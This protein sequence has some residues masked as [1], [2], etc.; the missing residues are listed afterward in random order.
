MNIDKLLIEPDKYYNAIKSVPNSL[1]IYF[2]PTYPGGAGGKAGG[3]GGGQIYASPIEGRGDGQKAN[4]PPWPV[5]VTGPKLVPIDS[6]PTYTATVDWSANG[7]NSMGSQTI[8]Q[9]GETIHYRWESFNITQYAEEALAKKTAE[10]KKGAAAPS[11]LSYE[12]RLENLKNAKVGAGEDVTGMGGANREFHREFEHWAQD[13]RRA[14]KGAKN[15]GGDTVGER[16]SNATANRLALELAPV[17]L[18]TTAIGATLAWMAE[19]FAGPRRQQE[20]PLQKKGI[21]LIRTITTPAI[22]EDREGKQI[23]RPPSVDA[24]ITE[25]T[26]METSVKEALDEPS[27]QLAELKAQIDLA[28]KEGNT[29]KAE[30]LRELLAQ[31]QV[32]HEGTPLAVL[33]KSKQDK[34]RE[35]DQLRKEK[36][37]SAADSRQ[38]EL[39]LID[40]Q[41]KLY[42]RHD[43]ERTKDGTDLAPM[44][45]LNATLISEVTGEQYPLLIAAGPMAKKGDQHQWMI[46]DVTT[47]DGDA[48]T[49][50][51]ATASAAFISALTKFGEKASY[52]RGRIGAR[53]TGLGLEAGAQETVYVD[54]APANWALAEKRLDDLV[55]TLAAI[56]LFV[57]SAGTASAAIGAAVAAARLI[58]RWQAG[59][60]YLDS[61]TVSD[62]LGLLGGIGAMG[63]LAAGLRVQKFEKVF[64]IVQDGKFTQTQFAAANEALKGAQRLAKGVELANE[65]MGYA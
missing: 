28:V 15:P 37:N 5:K 63:Q 48:Y 47:R 43:A 1:L 61:Q 4:A 2:A 34:Q 31:A 11:G 54:S 50:L 35:I 14:A 46:S 17:S 53:T 25:V 39:D 42:Q 55:M 30:Y 22:N 45:R 49:G 3:A 27:A 52:G 58:Q 60:L 16:L 33:N 64:A 20:V 57:A 12:E 7:N 51:G 19:L 62:V 18:L 36:R 38:R 10:D 9:L 21:Y 59:K 24:K 8:S 29:A 32:R 56:G 26:T 65:A 6:N 23:I 40:D 41:I 13:T 44:K